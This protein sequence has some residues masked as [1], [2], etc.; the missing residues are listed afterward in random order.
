MI[1]PLFSG[2]EALEGLP[3]WS[4]SN[5]IWRCC[6]TAEG[7]DGKI[8]IMLVYGSNERPKIQWLL[9]KHITKAVPG[10]H[11]AMLPR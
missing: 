7:R 8:W 9:F 2:W 1:F 10:K 11:V 6:E 3:R 4:S 5:D